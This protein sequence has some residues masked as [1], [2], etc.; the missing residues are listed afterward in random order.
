MVF[1]KV[2]RNGFYIP[3]NKELSRGNEYIIIPASNIMKF[4]M[5]QHIGTPAKPI[6]KVGDY[7]KVGEKIGNKVGAISANVHS[8]VS[9]KVVKIEYSNATRGNNVLCVY[10]ENDGKYEL[11][12]E[13]ID[14]DYQNLSSEEIVRIVEEAGI[15]G[16]GGASFPTHVKLSP[17]E[18]VDHVILNGA[19]C[20]PYLTSDDTMMRNFA[21]DI[22]VGLKIELHALNAPNG[23]ILIEDDKPEAIKAIK[24]ASKDDANIEVVVAETKY[25]QGD[26]KRVIDAVLGKEIPFGEN[27]Y[28]SGVIVSNVTTAYAIK[29]AV[30]HNKPLYERI[31]TFTG[32]AMNKK[33]NAL[34]QFGTPVRD[35]IKYIGG[36]DKNI[37]DRI[38]FGGPMMGYNQDDLSVPIEKPT[39]AVLALSKEETEK[40]DRDP[41]IKCAACVEVCPVGLQPFNLEV[42][43]SNGK[44]KEAKAN[45]VMSCIECGLCSYICPSHI[46]LVESFK[47]GKRMIR[48]LK[49]K[50]GEK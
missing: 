24:D 6:V 43:I 19:E 20:E 23:Y 17:S 41:C 50:K 30:C 39:N 3:G 36:T 46:P 1:S 7:V 12:Y 4:P 15:T 47:E 27:T 42:L 10:V 45:N 22:I 8:S 48:D 32:E 33:L 18:Q 9:G 40:P 11:G 37:I 14:R 21:E 34:I 38:I 5:L 49:L 29:Q 31:V 13:K 28:K 16:L 2:I 25:P 44:I 35:C 26:E